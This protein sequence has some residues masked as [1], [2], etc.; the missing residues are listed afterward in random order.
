MRSWLLKAAVQNII[1]RMPNSH[2]WNGLFQKHVT[3]AYYPKPDTFKEKL[4]ESDIS[5]GPYV[6]T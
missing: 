4:V 6:Q 5:F 1:G 2:F 3:K